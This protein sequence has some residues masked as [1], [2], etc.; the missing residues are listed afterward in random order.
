MSKFK[1]G[2]SVYHKS[3]EKKGVI[4]SK[5]MIKDWEIV[6]ADGK[7]G[8]HTEAELYTE[9]EYEEKTQRKTQKKNIR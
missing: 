3:T 8:Y 5:S 6:W 7:T 9:K 2:D 1:E 4:S